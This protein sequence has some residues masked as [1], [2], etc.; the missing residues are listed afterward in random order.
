MNEPKLTWAQCHTGA[1]EMLSAFSSAPAVASCC[2]NLPSSP[3]NDL[4]VGGG[5]SLIMI[6]GAPI[7]VPR[8]LSHLLS[9]T[10]SARVEDTRMS[11][12]STAGDANDGKV[13]SRLSAMKWKVRSIFMT[14]YVAWLI[15]RPPC[16]YVLIPRAVLVQVYVYRLHRLLYSRQSTRVTSSLS[17][18]HVSC[19]SP[20]SHVCVTR[21][22]HCVDRSRLNLERPKQ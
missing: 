19:P 16:Y 22:L 14:L 9:P 21:L 18:L 12:A 3:E 6:A 10:L 20:H 15:L 7:F 17:I 2:H 4:S 1:L 5:Y 11:L 8:C 13:V